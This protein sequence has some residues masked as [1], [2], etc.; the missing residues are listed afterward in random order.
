MI[1]GVL[2]TVAIALLCWWLSGSRNTAWTYQVEPDRYSA[3]G[4]LRLERS[5]G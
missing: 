2:L 1:T 3:L 5:M 4:E